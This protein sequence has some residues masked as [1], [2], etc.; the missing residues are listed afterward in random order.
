MLPVY[1]S[2]PPGGFEVMELPSKT[3]RIDMESGRVSG[4]TDGL[5]AVR[6]T[7]CHILSTERYEHVIFSWNHGSELKELYGRPQPYVQSELK[8]R[9][10]EALTQ[11]DRIRG[12]DAFSFERNKSSLSVTFTVHSVH[13]DFPAGTE[14]MT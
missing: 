6:Q 14:V 11:D 2:A 4:M 1:K 5:A 3:Y 8:R 12:V 13:G 7:V 10:K 9:I